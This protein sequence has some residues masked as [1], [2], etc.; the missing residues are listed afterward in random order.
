M[1]EETEEEIFIGGTADQPTESQNRINKRNMELC[2]T[3]YG[4]KMEGK[5]PA[6]QA[7][8]HIALQ[9]VVRNIKENGNWRCYEEVVRG[10]SPFEI[11]DRRRIQS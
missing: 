11:S 2:T 1:P 4:F 8:A 7:V 5:M 6:T 3:G 10:G 9:D